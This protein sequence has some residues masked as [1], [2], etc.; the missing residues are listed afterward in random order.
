MKEQRVSVNAGNV[1][2]FN[3]NTLSKYK[4][5]LTIRKSKELKYSKN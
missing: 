2:L 3:E 5:A 1:S 4:F